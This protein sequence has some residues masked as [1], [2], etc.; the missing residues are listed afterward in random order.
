MAKKAEASAERVI[1]EYCAIGFLDQRKFYDGDGSLLPIQ[2]MPERARRAI[3]GMDVEGYTKARVRS[4]VRS[5]GHARSASREKQPALDSLAK[6]LGLFQGGEGPGVNVDNINMMIS[7]PGAARLM[8]HLGERFNLDDTTRK[9]RVEL[10]LSRAVGR[11]VTLEQAVEALKAKGSPAARQGAIETS[12]APVPQGDAATGCT[13][14]A[15]RARFGH[16]YP[17]A[18]EPPAGPAGRPP[19]PLVRLRRTMRPA[20]RGQAYRAFR[21]RARSQRPGDRRRHRVSIVATAN[22][23]VTP[24][25][26]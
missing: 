7:D 4:A 26:G 9:R 21:A 14:G 1:A 13:H 3:A 20:K 19:A 22:I 15:A 24:A 10:T 17:A 18:S 25:I 2:Q 23:V 8:Q 11:V 16:G 6:H 12:A 5:A